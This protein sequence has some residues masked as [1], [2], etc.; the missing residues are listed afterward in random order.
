MSNFMKPLYLIVAVIVGSLAFGCAG[1]TREIIVTDVSLKTM[2]AEPDFLEP[3]PAP[4]SLRLSG[5]MTLKECFVKICHREKPGPTDTAY[6]FGL[7]KIKNSYVAFFIESKAYKKNAEEWMTKK[8]VDYLDKYYPLSKNEYKGLSWEQ[9]L[10]KIRSELK[11]FS[12][13][14]QFK[15]SSLAKAKS[16]TI[17]FDD[18]KF[19]RLK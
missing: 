18:A 7:Y 2:E 3:P 14:D 9:F 19:L 11:K 17:R 13:T 1:K 8:G 12:D 4:P 10:D 6:N 5:A 16:I 15:S